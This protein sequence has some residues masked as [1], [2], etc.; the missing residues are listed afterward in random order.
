[1]E[2]FMK[3]T[4][5]QSAALAGLIMALYIFGTGALLLAM[6]GCSNLRFAPTEAQKT[7]AY[8]HKETTSAIVTNY[9][10]SPSPD[11]NIMALCRLSDLQAGNVLAYYGIPAKLPDTNMI[12]GLR[13]A[14]PAAIVEAAA[15]TQQAAPDSVKRP[16]Y[17]DGAET[18][19]GF[20]L[21]I[22]GLYTGSAGALKL[23]GWISYAL[24]S[25][26]ALREVVEANEALKTRLPIEGQMDF[27]EVNKLVQSDS[28]VNLIDD[29]RTE[30]AKR[31]A[32]KTV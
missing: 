12:E 17:W 6:T 27:K 23:K 15:V 18:L 1:M 26:K 10:A 28:T 11:P 14:K 7:D 29:L 24:A 4:R 13:A 2:A 9:A 31:D 19:L 22:V 8:L 21:A 5:F 3:L 25:I 30:L 32:A 16:N 20:V